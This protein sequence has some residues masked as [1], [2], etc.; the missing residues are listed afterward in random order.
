M[1]SIERLLSEHGPG[2]IRLRL[3]E[4]KL[5]HNGALPC[6][7]WLYNTKPPHAHG[8]PHYCKGVGM[9]ERQAQPVTNTTR[10]RMET[11]HI[12][13]DRRHEDPLAFIERTSHHHIDTAWGCLYNDQGEIVAVVNLYDFHER[14]KNGKLMRGGRVIARTRADHHSLLCFRQRR[15]QREERRTS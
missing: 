8:M 9:R 11:K 3:W 12:T 6:Q 10:T 13:E 7:G 1:A 2:R 5:S 4:P 15:A 14:N